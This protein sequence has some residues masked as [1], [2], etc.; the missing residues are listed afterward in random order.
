MAAKPQSI[1]G[2]VKA[3]KGSPGIDGMSVFSGLPGI[4]NSEDYAST[5][6]VA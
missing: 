5:V 6:V 2:Q 1:Q 3:N 4:A